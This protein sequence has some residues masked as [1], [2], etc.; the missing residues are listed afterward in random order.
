MSDNELLKLCY[1]AWGFR[2]HS[3]SSKVLYHSEYGISIRLDQWDPLNDSAQA[4]DMVERF[5][6]SVHKMGTYWCVNDKPNDTENTGKSADLKR[7][8]VECVAKRQRAM[9]PQL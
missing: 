3:M 6:L 7:A 2:L 8:I 9:L 4:L 5:G 1:E